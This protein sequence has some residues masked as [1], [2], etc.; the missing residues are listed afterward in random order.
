MPICDLK[1]MLW[2][3]LNNRSFI[4]ISKRGLGTCGTCAVEATG[5]VEPTERNTTERL[6]LSFP[7]HGSDQQSP[8]LRLAC[9]VQVRG[10]IKVTKRS[11][12]WGQD[13][14]TLS[15]STGCETYFGDLEFVLDDKS[16]DV[17]RVLHE[18]CKHEYSENTIVS[19]ESIDM[20]R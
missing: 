6:R 14:D 17:W 3:I 16:P 4:G 5:S 15:E 19:I 12:F 9:Q 20:V 10:D 18:Q 13:I 11:G 8:N 7:P 1:I 2:L